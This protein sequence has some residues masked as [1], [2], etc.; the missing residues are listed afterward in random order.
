M[1]DFADLSPT[2]RAAAL[3]YEFAH[4]R[5]YTARRISERYGISTRGAYKL[6]NRISRAIPLY[7]DG[8]VWR[9][10]VA[11]CDKRARH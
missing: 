3:A 1:S 10:L 7:E 11:D 5:A 9:V 6:V 4:G 8:G 2:E